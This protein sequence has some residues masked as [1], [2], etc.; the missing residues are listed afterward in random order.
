MIE[1]ITQTV[2]AASV[3]AGIVIG[4]ASAS[5]ALG[6]GEFWQD[7]ERGINLKVPVPILAEASAEL[8]DGP[9]GIEIVP[10]NYTKSR[11]MAAAYLAAFGVSDVNLRI[12]I[13]D[14]IPPGHGFATSS[15]DLV[16]TATAI[17]RLFGLVHDQ[18]LLADL[19]AD[20]EPT[21]AA[22][23]DGR[24]A[25]CNFRTGKRISPEY[26]LPRGVYVI[27]YPIGRPL[28]TEVVNGKRPRYRDLQRGI[29]NTTFER[30]PRILAARSLE[31]LASV[32][33]ASAEVN[34][35]YFGKP[36]IRALRRLRQR[37]KVAGYM[38]AHSGSA[39]G[40]VAPLANVTPVF[41]DFLDALGT[42]YDVVGF[43]VEAMTERLPFAF[44]SGPSLVR[45]R[46]DGPEYLWRQH[47]LHGRQPEVQGG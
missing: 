26:L 8:L 34:N 20:I 21:D 28:D 17:G 38:V 2:S 18:D 39:V 19:M 40:V 35:L 33:A 12:T 15:R 9:P 37:G 25:L 23:S 30:L 22:I 47:G 4:T 46:T 16:N 24:I 6:A 13:S 14:S 10:Q 42:G 32:A 7:H 29:L 44:G 5:S 1:P 43:C 11:R 31:G 45:A 36:E 3:E 27:G 41:K